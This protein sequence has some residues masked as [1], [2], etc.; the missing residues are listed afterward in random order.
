VNEHIG[1]F[2]DPSDVLVDPFRFGPCLSRFG[3]QGKSPLT[4]RSVQLGCQ[5][6]NQTRADVLPDNTA[7]DAP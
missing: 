4:I 1:K 7:V 5:L 6:A 3:L 2:L